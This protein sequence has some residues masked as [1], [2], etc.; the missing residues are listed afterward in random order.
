MTLIPDTMNRKIDESQQLQFPP[1]SALEKHPA[2]NNCAL[3]SQLPPLPSLLVTD[4]FKTA[5]LQMHKKSKLRVLNNKE[6][7][8]TRRPSDIARPVPPPGLFQ[9]A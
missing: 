1:A 2:R 5:H 8:K 9:T 4:F 3:Y 6:T 7:I